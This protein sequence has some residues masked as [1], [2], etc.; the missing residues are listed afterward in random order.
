MKTGVM[1]FLC[2]KSA[3]FVYIFWPFLYKLI[4]IEDESQLKIS[5][6]VL[7]NI[8]AKINRHVLILKKKKKIRC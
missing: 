1:Q 4:I 3:M 5:A 6:V 2:G 8:I 7:V